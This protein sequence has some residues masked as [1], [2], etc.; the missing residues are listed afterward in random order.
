ML[1]LSDEYKMKPVNK[2]PMP[3]LVAD[4]PL[5]VADL[6]LLVADQQ[7][8]NKILLAGSQDEVMHIVD[9]AMTAIESS[10]ADSQVTS[11]MI[12]QIM[13]DLE[14]RNPLKIDAQQWS[15]IKMAMILFN[16]IRNRLNSVIR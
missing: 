14:V 8:M 15:N 11:G 9:E 3:L 4:L 13:N 10:E 2:I 6:P 5:L 1:V 16:R 7:L 12:E